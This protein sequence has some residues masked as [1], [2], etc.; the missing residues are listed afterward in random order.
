MSDKTKIGPAARLAAT[1]AT[2]IDPK[3]KDV[4]LSFHCGLVGYL[5]THAVHTEHKFSAVAEAAAR[6]NWPATGMIGQP[7][8]ECRASQRDSN[9]PVKAR[10]T[11]ASDG[12]VVCLRG[13][14]PT[15]WP[16]EVQAI[17]DELRQL[18]A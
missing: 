9:L 12:T 3:G 8:E 11:M 17:I 18:G 16:P 7:C 14:E 10:Y 13:H 15:T 6:F 1:A 4:R 2:I 5:E